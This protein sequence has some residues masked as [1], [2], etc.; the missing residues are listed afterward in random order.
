L[1]LTTLQVNTTPKGY[2]KLAAFLDSDENFMT[3][4]RFGYLQSRLLVEKQNDLQV[5]EDTL[6][7]MDQLAVENDPNILMSRV[8]YGHESMADRISL[9]TSI[10]AKWL[11]YC[12]SLKQK[13]NAVDWKSQLTDVW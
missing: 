5:L 11:E 6:D 3:Y 12:K 2:P 13:G 7:R 10:E 1:A 9:L 8:D 4:R